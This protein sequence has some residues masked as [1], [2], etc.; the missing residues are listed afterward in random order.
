[1]K[2]ALEKNDEGDG[3]SLTEDTMSRLESLAQRLGI[4]NGS[5]SSTIYS[6]K[7]PSQDKKKRKKE[8]KRERKP[9]DA[10]TFLAEILVLLIFLV[11]Q[12][13]PFPGCG[14]PLN[15][16]SYFALLLYSHDVVSRLRNH[17]T[18]YF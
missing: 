11:L 4:L 6:R 8:K 10:Q 7:S 18:E 15:G 2:R 1:M 3:E 13:S 12:T 9:F 5:T 17:D 16:L 14:R